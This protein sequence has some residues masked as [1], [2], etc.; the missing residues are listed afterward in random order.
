[1]K[2]AFFYALL[3]LFFISCGGGSGGSNH[4]SKP[5]C[6]NNIIKSGSLIEKDY[7]PLAQMSKT[8]KV[9]KTKSELDR[10]FSF[11]GDEKSPQID[12]TKSQVLAIFMGSKTTG[13]YSLNIKGI[14]EQN[15]IYIENKLQSHDC[16]VTADM[17]YPYALV[18]Y[19]KPQ[20]DSKELAI[21]ES[22]IHTD[23][24]GGCPE[25]YVI[26]FK[27]Q[28]EDI[29]GFESSLGKSKNFGVIRR[30]ERFDEVFIG[31]EK[32]SVDFEKETII[33]A[34][35]G[36]FSRAGHDI[37]I[38]KIMREEEYTKVYIKS[39]YLDKTCPSALVITSPKVFVKIPK[40]DSYNIIFEEEK[41]IVRCAI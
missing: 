10:Y 36:T 13:V 31:S 16:K 6:C 39:Y 38:D 9:I 12:F 4:F 30:K 11:I 5:K 41:D 33:Y 18:K 7:A 26:P 25:I 1:M 8:I 23:T 40:K 29:S 3:G 28:F 2:K 35:L 19:P 34:H 27:V 17:A 24:G 20:S 22:Y 21:K 15:N 37:K 32:P 14:D